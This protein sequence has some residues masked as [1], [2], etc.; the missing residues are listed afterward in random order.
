M[1]QTGHRSVQMLRRYIRDGNLFRGEQ[2]RETGALGES[3]SGAPKGIECR[4]LCAA[5]CLS[6]SHFHIQLGLAFACHKVTVLSAGC[7]YIRSQ[8]PQSFRVD[9]F[10]PDQFRFKPLAEYTFH[11]ANCTAKVI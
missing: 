1:N 5:A 10:Q 9:A 8:E 6:S 11:R 3:L 2:R 4:H 7:S